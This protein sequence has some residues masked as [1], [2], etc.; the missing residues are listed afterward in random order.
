MLNNAKNGAYERMGL[1]GDILKLPQEHPLLP[2]PIESLKSLPV[3]L[4][5]LAK[6]FWE[7]V[8]PQFLNRD[9]SQAA[10]CPIR[11]SPYKTQF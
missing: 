9:V 4:T 7:E 3:D 11:T 5:Y 1:D 10:R 2:M 8:R 6:M